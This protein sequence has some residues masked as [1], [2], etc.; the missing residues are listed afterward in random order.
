MPAC[1][2]AIV[3]YLTI[4]FRIIQRWSNR[5]QI[6]HGRRLTGLLKEQHRMKLRLNM[7]RYGAKAINTFEFVDPS[8]AKLPPFSAG[9]HV[10]LCLPNGLVRQYSLCN[11]PIERSH[12]VLGVRLESRGRGGSRCMHKNVHCGDLLDISPPT[13]SFPLN[14]KARRHLLIA[15]GIGITPVMS[16]LYALQHAQAEFEIYY[17]ARSPEHMAF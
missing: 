9:A 17:C 3:C 7:I 6:D 8:G 5:R 4:S 13:N 16:M 14:S 11:D 1:K 10:D 12:Y 2:K 15:G